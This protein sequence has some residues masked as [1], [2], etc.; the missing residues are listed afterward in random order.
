MPKHCEK[1]GLKFNKEPGFF[2]GAMYVGYSLSVAY[3]VAFYIA[4]VVLIGDFKVEM[5]FLFGIGSLV[6]LTP[7]V[8]KLSRSLWI[9]MFVNYEPAYIEKWEKETEGK[10][11]DNPCIEV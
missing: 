7:V 10:V 2:Y 3:L 8:F 4:M 11:I 9:A 1:C 5:Y 6:L